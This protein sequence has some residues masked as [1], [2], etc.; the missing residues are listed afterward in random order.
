MKPILFA[1]GPLDFYSFGVF[2]AAGVLVSIY[3]MTRQAQR[4]GFLKRDD[5]FDL[6]FVVVLSGF[7]GG[8]LLYVVQ[9]YEWYMRNPIKIFA[10]WEGGLIFYGGVFASFAGVFFFTRKKKISF[11][12]G[13]DFLAPYIAL[14][15]S[16]GRIGCFLN[17]CC[18]GK[19]CSLPWA[20]HFPGHE[21]SL[22]PTQL[23]EAVFTL[24]MFVF[25]Y[26]RYGRKSF[27]GEIIAFYFCLYALG[28]FAIEFFRADNPSWQ[29]LTWNQWLS[30]V[31]FACV[32]AWHRFRKHPVM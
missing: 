31:V 11:S 7:L 13:L 18:Y 17:G 2:V 25:L 12:K 15:Q 16:F 10:I 3:L 24:C 14:T 26:Y 32:F 1:I 22:H 29:Y 6:V 27:D 30:L 19:E 8:R 5:V 9:Y 28:R 21:I 20:V 23:Y 4:E